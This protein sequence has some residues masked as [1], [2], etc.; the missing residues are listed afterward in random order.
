MRETRFAFITAVILLLVLS[1]NGLYYVLNYADDIRCIPEPISDGE[2]GYDGFY[3]HHDSNSPGNIGYSYSS[4]NDITDRRNEGS[5]DDLSVNILLLGLDRDKTRCDA[6]MLLNFDPKSPALNIL[7]IA[8]DTRVFT[9]RGYRKINSFYSSGGAG[10]VAR[11]VS[12]ITGLPVHYYVTADFKGFRKVIDTLGGVEFNVPFRMNYDDP[13]QNL[14]IHLK[15]GV[16]VL[17]GKKA[18]QLVRY[19]K[20]N[21]KGQGYTEGDIGRIRMQ[22][23]FMKA[24]IDQKLKLRYLSRADDIFAILADYV[25]TNITISDIARYASGAS[26]LSSSSIKT[27]VLPGE[28]YII[29]NVWWY[30]YD[31]EETAAM[32]EENFV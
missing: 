6:I 7:S 24:L 27:F 18:E 31:R 16:Q 14:H 28:S 11:E 20:G 19:R 25:K 26:K 23:D 4:D 29:D 22:Q 30:I 9:G 21:Y 8:R 32:I 1:A 3:S 2:L 13:T 5:T 12:G 15:K 17:N 10:G